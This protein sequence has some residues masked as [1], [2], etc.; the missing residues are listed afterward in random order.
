[1]PYGRSPHHADRASIGSLKL[2]GRTP[3]GAAAARVQTER[4][5]TV[6]DR[7]GGASSVVARRISDMLR[8]HDDHSVAS[9]RR[10]RTRRRAARAHRNEN[11]VRPGVDRRPE[12]GAA[13]RRTYRRRVPEDRLAPSLRTPCRAMGTPHRTSRRLR[14]PG[15]Q[16]HLLATASEAQERLTGVRAGHDTSRLLQNVDTRRIYG[17]EGEMIVGTEPSS[18]ATRWVRGTGF[19]VLFGGPTAV[20]STSAYTRWWSE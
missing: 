14:L 19:G 5:P 6:R 15:L 8:G 7:P 20:V 13:A 16:P 10:G 11:R 9:E 4:R 3:G 2:V 18:P 1:M 17:E 12:T